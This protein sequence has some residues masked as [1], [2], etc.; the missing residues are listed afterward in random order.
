MDQDHALPRQ[1]VMQNFGLGRLAEAPFAIVI[2]NPNLDDNPIVYV[3]GAFERQT[4]YS[5]SAS[6][7]RN[8]RFLQGE[9][10]EP[11][12]V[13]TLRS[14]IAAGDAA[15]VELTNYRADGTAYLNRLIIAP[16]SDGDG[17]LRY[18]CGIQVAPQ[19]DLASETRRADI[20]DRALAEVQHR[21]KNHLAMIVSLIRIQARDSQDDPAQDFRTL[22][23]RVEALQLLY[24]ELGSDRG[25]IIR[26][27]TT[28]QL[29]SYLTR[30]ANAIAHL[31]G[32]HGIRVNI[33]ADD[34]Q[35]SFATATQIGLTLSEIMTNAL[36]HAFADTPQGLV[37]VRVQTMS[38]GLIRLSV[39][40]D[41]R[42]LP[43]DVDWPNE[44]NLGSR[45]VRQL[46]D[47]LGGRISVNRATRGTTVSVD[48][49]RGGGESANV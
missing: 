37:E 45:I 21:V 39:A 10:T 32:R 25:D 33:N 44:G 43:Q 18:F 1:L 13:E 11:A 8:C 40:D 27:D 6:V 47:G 17:N 36:Q 28:I 48:I 23:R 20:A 9:G 29:G 31:D 3:N 46:V 4:G 5:L 14:A 38:D 49:P 16:L 41:G 35:T 2:T 30:V 7:G 26:N 12:A 24:E 34:I 22:A 15:S 19:I 42:G